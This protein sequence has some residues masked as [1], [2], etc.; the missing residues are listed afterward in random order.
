MLL[1]A[2][3]LNVTTRERV[4]FE[5]DLKMM[6]CVN[7]WEMS[8]GHSQCKGP[9][10]GTHCIAEVRTEGARGRVIGGDVRDCKEGP[11]HGP[12]GRLWQ[13]RDFLSE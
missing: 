4:A 1:G 2:A 11:V 5:Q 9:G 8:L 12:S 6:S 7:A 3:I 10:V 13:K